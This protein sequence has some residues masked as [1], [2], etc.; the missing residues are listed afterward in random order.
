MVV[1]DANVPLPGASNQIFYPMD[2]VLATNAWGPTDERV[3]SYRR[4]DVGMDLAIR[5]SRT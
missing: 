5:G 3:R 4:A 1:F 2:C